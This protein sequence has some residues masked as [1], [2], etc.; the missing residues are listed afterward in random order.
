MNL[1]D[2][3]LFE[4]EYSYSKDDWYAPVKLVLGGLK[5]EQAA[6][7]SEGQNINSIWEIAAHLLYYKERL[8]QRLQGETPEYAS[9]NED[10]FIYEGGTQADW[11]ALVSRMDQVN[12]QFYQLL[13]KVED[14]ENHP[15]LKHI[16]GVIRHDAHHAGQIII[17][18]KLQGAWPV[19]KDS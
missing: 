19:E 6:W 2:L 18:R 13:Q 7:K 8:V 10:T 3:L 15:L 17:N 12:Q 1:V 9:K 4:N 11:D 5:A 16:S 14:A